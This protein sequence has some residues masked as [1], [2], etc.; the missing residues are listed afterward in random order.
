MPIKDN[1]VFIGVENKLVRSQANGP[2]IFDGAGRS[3]D[4]C[5]IFG[6]TILSFNQSDAMII[7]VH[8]H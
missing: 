3:G 6:P 1:M 8:Y 4:C 7:P 5:V 2:I